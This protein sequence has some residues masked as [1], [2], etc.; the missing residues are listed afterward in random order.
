MRVYHGG[1]DR[2]ERPRII[3]STRTLDYGQGFYTTS[4]FGQAEQWVRRKIIEKEST[5]YVNIYE[6]NETL[7]Q[8]DYLNVLR[9][10]TPT[11]EWVDFVMVNRLNRQFVHLYDVVWGPVANDRVYAA[12]SLFESGILDK[13]ELIRE[14]KTYL[15]FDQMLFH[16]EKA[17]SALN[18]IGAKEIRL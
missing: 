11:S 6:I 8:T 18:F 14:L 1:L 13:N 16:T 5:G 2:I 12:F 3:Q 17:L 10:K 7:L 9:F 4:S 15:L